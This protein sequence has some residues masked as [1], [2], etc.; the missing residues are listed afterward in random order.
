MLKQAEIDEL[1]AMGCVA[2]VLCNFLDANGRTIDHPANRRVM[3]VN[4][5]D[6]AKAGH[7]VIAAGGARRVA[8][9]RAAI[10]RIGCDTLITDEGA[11]RALLE[12]SRTSAG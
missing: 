10:A 6:L 12:R 7:I 5:D 8:A 1:T 4:L 3:S 2:D 9:I 11:A